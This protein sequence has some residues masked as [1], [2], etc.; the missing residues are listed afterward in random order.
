MPAIIFSR[1]DMILFQDLQWTYND[2]NIDVF[3]VATRTL[4]LTTA[5]L[6]SQRRTL[7][8][9]Y[10]SVT[11]KPMDL[12]FAQ[13][14]NF[15]PEVGRVSWG[16]EQESA[17]LARTLAGL[18]PNTQHCTWKDI[19]IPS[20]GWNLSPWMICLSLPVYEFQELARQSGINKNGKRASVKAW[21]HFISWRIWP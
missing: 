9:C 5:L 8:P 3:R 1:I 6:K 17:K 21:N 7:P 16:K 19:S 20:A 14:Y 12:Y 4:Q 15:S 2:L 11:H 18:K 10:V 13:R